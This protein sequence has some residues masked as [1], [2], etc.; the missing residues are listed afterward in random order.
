MDKEYKGKKILLVDD[1]VDYLKSFSHILRKRGYEVSIAQSGFQAISHLEIGGCDIVL[2]DVRMPQM[3]GL[4][5]LEH[6]KKRWPWIC[7]I[8]VTS[9][10]PDRIA[11][12][13]I[14]KGAFDHISKGSIQQILLGI[15]RGLK[16]TATM[17]SA[18]EKQK[19]G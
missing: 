18:Y 5:L 14:E 12:E 1:D 8:V 6:I 16:V 17:R 3:D 4:K 19:A 2:V 13:S 7:V 9:Y 10:A 11:I 15:E